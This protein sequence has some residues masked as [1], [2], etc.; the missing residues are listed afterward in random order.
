MDKADERPN[1]LLTEPA[2]YGIVLYIFVLHSGIE[3]GLPILGRRRVLSLSDERASPAPIV[4]LFVLILG[5]LPDL[6]CVKVDSKGLLLVISL[7]IY[8]RF[9]NL[10]NLLSSTTPGLSFLVILTLVINRW[11]VVLSK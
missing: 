4:A 6:L 5:S 7:Y 9:V 2:A 8:G 10:S 11:P 1:F 3:H